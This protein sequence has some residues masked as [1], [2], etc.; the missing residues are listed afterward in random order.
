MRNMPIDERAFE[1]LTDAVRLDLSEAESSTLHA[2]L[3]ELLQ[4]VESLLELDL[5]AV[6]PWQPLAGHGP[7]RADDVAASLPAEV[8]LALAPVAQ[9]S[10]FEV[11]RTVDDD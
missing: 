7:G 1:Q 8:A 9:G 11:P 2:H 5:S 10:Y 6:E 3:N 4:S